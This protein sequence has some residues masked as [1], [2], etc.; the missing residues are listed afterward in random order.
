MKYQPKVEA[1]ICVAINE[2]PINEQT[3]CIDVSC[4]WALPVDIRDSMNNKVDVCLENSCKRRC[5]RSTE[6]YTANAQPSHLIFLCSE[7]G[8]FWRL[9]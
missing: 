8:S 5:I 9:G 1:S 6:L 2:D 3:M 4:P 7:G